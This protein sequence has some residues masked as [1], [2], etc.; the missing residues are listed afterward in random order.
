M[1]SPDI[2]N[3]ADTEKPVLK[4][5]LTL[6]LKKWSSRLAVLFVLNGWMG[7]AGC[8]TAPQPK[9]NAE[10][11]DA[12]PK[13]TL[14]RAIQAAKDGE[15]PDGSE[16][17]FGKGTTKEE[18]I[19]NAETAVKILLEGNL[20]FKS[21]T[22]PLPDRQFLAI[23]RGKVEKKT[24][25]NPE[26]IKKRLLAQLNVK[27]DGD[28]PDGS[29]VQ[30]GK[31]A[32]IKE[33]ADNAKAIIQILLDSEAINYTTHS[34]PI[35]NKWIAVVKGIAKKTAIRHADQPEKKEPSKKDL[36]RFYAE[37]DKGKKNEAKLEI[38]EGINM[39][40]SFFQI[41]QKCIDHYV[42]ELEK[43][44]FAGCIGRA[45]KRNPDRDYSGEIKVFV[46]VNNQGKVYRVTTHT[47]TKG[48]T[49]QEEKK[50]ERCVIGNVKRW[51]L[52]KKPKRKRDQRNFS[53]ELFF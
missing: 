25:P 23:V 9:P 5:R 24:G 17:Q 51:P 8:A 34:E 30:F 19:E 39:F 36:N 35:G 4:N 15:Q 20:V 37:L 50:I 52:P 40:K 29:E 45:L 10:A 2:Q 18:A 3:P 43:G 16:V 21:H 41:D 28:Q 26:M 49:P 42:S 11:Q 47:K 53:F 12:D 31:G 1:S 48:F 32:T 7:M 46:R 13:Q 44:P 27:K 22:T 14:L 38:R 6:S 33:A